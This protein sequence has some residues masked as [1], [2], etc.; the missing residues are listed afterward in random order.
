M[1]SSGVNTTTVAPD[2]RLQDIARVLSDRVRPELVLLF[3]SRARGAEHEDS[4]YDLMIVVRDPSSVE[5]ARAAAYEVLRAMQLSVDVIARSVDDYRRYQSDPGFLDFM[6]AREGV[7]LYASGTVPQLVQQRVREGPSNEGGVAMW[8]KRAA[9]DM[10]I[11]ER[12]LMS[13][14]PS[15]DAICFHAHA[16]VEKWLKASIVLHARTFPP[17]THDLS[18]LL[19]VQPTAIGASVAVREA[20]ALLMA[21]Y[22]KSRYPEAGMPTHA[23]AIAAVDAARVVK[24][25]VLPRLAE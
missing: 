16:A 25:L 20:C 9:S 3:G 10:S 24:N 15:I 2:S 5:A 19:E 12:D 4:D 23:E 13:A 17:K 22:P 7:L 14:D 18:D 11:A 1:L 21:L 6:V 8:L